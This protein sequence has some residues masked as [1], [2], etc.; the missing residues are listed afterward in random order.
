MCP[1]RVQ[2][3]Y[4]SWEDAATTA[5]G[6]PQSCSPQPP[7]PQLQASVCHI[8]PGN[9][10]VASH[11]KYTVIIFI[12]SHA[13]AIELQDRVVV[14]GGGWPAI[15]TVQVYN[16][17]GPQEQLPSLQTPRSWHACAHYMDNQDRVVSMLH[18]TS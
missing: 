15:A 10:C 17:S 5:P 12:S 13:C 11:C 9:N 3:G 8:G 2:P 14:T 1:G 4:F 7:T 6:P 18:V 16:I